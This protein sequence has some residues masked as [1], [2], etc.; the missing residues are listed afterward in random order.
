[1]AEMPVPKGPITMIS[2]SNAGTT[3]IV[4]GGAANRMSVENGTRRENEYY[5]NRQC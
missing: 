4:E 1:M 5:T 3:E 2:G